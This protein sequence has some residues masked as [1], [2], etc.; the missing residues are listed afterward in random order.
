MH[1]LKLSHLASHVLRYTPIYLNSSVWQRSRVSA[2][3][4]RGMGVNPSNSKQV[5]RW[6][7]QNSTCFH[8]N[9]RRVPLYRRSQNLPATVLR[10]FPLINIEHHLCCELRF[11]VSQRLRFT[12][13][14]LSHWY[15]KRKRKILKD[16]TD[17]ARTQHS[18]CGGGGSR[19]WAIKRNP[20]PVEE[21][22]NWEERSKVKPEEVFLHQGRHLARRVVMSINY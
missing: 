16:G 9:G 6:G 21:W 14:A 13:L 10:D 1:I 8:T 20:S 22:W 2:S 3:T 15:Q 18:I 7:S 5:Q 19:A 12:Y 11:W 17:I 4:L